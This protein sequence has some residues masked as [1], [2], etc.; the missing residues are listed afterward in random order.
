[1]LRRILAML[2]LALVPSVPLA[3]AQMRDPVR[4]EGSWSGT[5]WMGKYEEP[6]EIELLQRGES[7][8][9]RV[10]MLGYPAG[11]DENLSESAAIQDG[12]ID[13][14]RVVLAWSM[15]A[16]RFTASLR[17]TSAGTLMG[18]AHEDGRVAT[19]LQLDRV[20]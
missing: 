9:G 19:G 11:H 16:R 1:M 7:F 12:W 13:G 17:F 8:S 3:W 6:I 18:L 10:S 4:L 15:G 5:W 14:D 2:A 20:R